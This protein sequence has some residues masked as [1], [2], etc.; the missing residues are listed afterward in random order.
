[1]NNKDNNTDDNSG[2]RP[3]LAGRVFAINGNIITVVG[4]QDERPNPTSTP[5][6][7]TVNATN[8]TVVVKKDKGTSTLSS[9]LVGDMIMV[10][11]T[12]IRI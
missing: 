5:V 8:T 1:M 3:V 2:V 7:Y 10:Q 4:R 9:I 11:G 12:V 6:T